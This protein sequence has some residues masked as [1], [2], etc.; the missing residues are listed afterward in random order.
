MF[1]AFVYARVHPLFTHVYSHCS[2][3]CARS[4]RKSKSDLHPGIDGISADEQKLL[5]DAAKRGRRMSAGSYLLSKA[6]AREAFMML[7]REGNGYLNKEDVFEALHSLQFDERFNK[8]DQAGD[9]EG[10]MAVVE[11]MI[12]DIDKDGDGKIDLEEFVAV[13]TAAD[14]QGRSSNLQSRMSMLAHKVVKSHQKREESQIGNSH[15]LINPNNEL[16]RYASAR[17]NGAPYPLIC[18]NPSRPPACSTS[19]WRCSSF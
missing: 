1:M 19:S 12:N 9:H 16:H 18:T 10:A 4:S 7:D 3:M 13:L 15:G 14:S 8:M 17:A 6:R 11:T 5:D 2:H